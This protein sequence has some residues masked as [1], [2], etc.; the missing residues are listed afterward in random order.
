MQ[1]RGGAGLF[2]G[3]TPFVWVSNNYGRTGTRQTTIQARGL[4]E[5]NPDPGDQPTG[6]GGASS[7]E[8]N[9]VDPD[10]NFPQTWRANIAY[11]H[12]L[13][14]LNMVATAE[15]MYA[16]STNE[17]NYQNLNIQQ[18]GE[19]LPFD[20]RPLYETVSRDYSGAYYL[21]NT[22]KGDATNFIFR[23]EKPYGDYPFW[24]TMSYTWGESNVVND[25]TSSR[26]VSNWQYTEAVDP[27][28]VGLSSSDFQVEHRGVINLNYEL[29]GSSKWS[30]V[31][32]VFWLRQSG[33][34][35][36]NIYNWS[37]GSINE[38]FYTSNDL[39]YIPSGADDVVITNGTWGQLDDYLQRTGLDKYK[40]EIA[41]RNVSQQP[42]VTQTDV[43]I[44]QNIGI[45]GRSSL[46]ITLD[47]FNFWNLIDSDSGLVRYVNFG[48]VTPIT[49]QGVT[50]DGK[51]IYE[52]RGVVTDP[53]N[54]DIFTFNDLRSR[55]RMR[56]GI[57]WSF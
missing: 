4:I 50:E 6:V 30:T 45:P 40:G 2:T 42:W 1:L 24:G 26:A 5:F 55:W 13:P 18:T 14:W 29:N 51:P 8:I 28:N 16:K 57:R 3:R 41:P 25:G 36:T 37:Y 7:E 17:I 9:A 27:N 43:S 39:I 22:D 33:K 52:L 35:Y 49:Y 15:V 53:E 44:R 31:L 56:L 38:D 20:G 19:N 54:N 11:D 10:F 12:R 21:I 32:S 47:I 34:P 48:T 23:L 46:Q